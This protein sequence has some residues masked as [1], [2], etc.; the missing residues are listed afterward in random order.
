MTPEQQRLAAEAQLRQQQVQA[1]LEAELARQ[2]AEW[3]A[4]AVTG[5]YGVQGTKGGRHI[6][7]K[8]ATMTVIDDVSHPDFWK[9]TEYNDVAKHIRNSLARIITVQRDMEK[10]RDWR[11]TSPW[12]PKR[13]RRWLQKH[14]KPLL[15]TLFFGPL[16]LGFLAFM[17]YLYMEVHKASGG[18]AVPAGIAWGL[19]TA[20]YFFYRLKKL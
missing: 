10:M 11:F 13:W 5:I 19:L 4:H 18:H 20:G 7:G 9:N 16:F 3:Q 2:Q 6:Q 8:S 14:K 12:H 17:A 1:Q 15:D